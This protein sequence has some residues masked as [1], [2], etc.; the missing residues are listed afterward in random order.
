[1]EDH[2]PCAI[3]LF[4]CASHP[5]RDAL[6]VRSNKGGFFRKG[7]PL[8]ILAG[9]FHQSKEVFTLVAS[10]RALPRMSLFGL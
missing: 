3:R 5:T 1:M 10:D 9:S 2:F 6:V 4:R 8:L 7:I